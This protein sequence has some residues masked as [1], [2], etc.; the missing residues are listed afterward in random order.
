MFWDSFSEGYF[1]GQAR[2]TDRHLSQISRKHESIY[3]EAVERLLCG[4]ELQLPKGCH[5]STPD[6]ALR[7]DI[8]YRW[9]EACVGKTYQQ[10]VFPPTNAVASDTIINAPKHADYPSS[11][12]LTFFGHYALPANSDPICLPNLACLDLGCGKG[13]ALTAYSWDGERE[14]DSSKFTTI[15]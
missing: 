8:R 13:G 5:F 3:G 2:L 4:P 12:P 10:M 7:K 15:R 11:E 6:G 9:W 1:P 14:L